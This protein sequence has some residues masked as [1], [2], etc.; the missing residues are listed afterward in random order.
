M[1]CPYLRAIPAGIASVHVYC[2]DSPTPDG[3]TISPSAAGLRAWCRTESD[4]AL[5]PRYQE[6]ATAATPRRG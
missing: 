4:Y 2:C 1:A 3:R 6:A 5:C